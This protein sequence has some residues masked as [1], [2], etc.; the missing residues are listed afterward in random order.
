MKSFQDWEPVVLNKK[1]QHHNNQPKTSNISVSLPKVE[2]T[3]DG[4]EVMKKMKTWDIKLIKALQ[5]ARM[6][7]GLTQEKLA[8]MLNM[9]GNIIKDIESNNTPYNEKLYRTIMRRLGVN[10]KS[11]EFP[12]DK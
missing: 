6:A 9:K 8:N 2:Y 3:D 10:L 4:E 11:I 1:V 12:V 7:K 5:E